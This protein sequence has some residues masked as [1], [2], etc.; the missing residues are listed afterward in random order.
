[1]WISAV[2]LKIL[3]QPKHPDEGGSIVDARLW[4]LQREWS[5]QER[6]LRERR[7]QALRDGVIIKAITRET[8]DAF[9]DH[10]I[11][12]Q[13]RNMVL[14]RSVHSTIRHQLQWPDTHNT[15]AQLS[16]IGFSNRTLTEHLV[17]GAEREPKFKIMQEYLEKK[18]AIWE[19][20]IS[21]RI[22]EGTLKMVVPNN[23]VPR[24]W[25]ID[26]HDYGLL[27]HTFDGF[28]LYYI[29]YLPQQTIAFIEDAQLLDYAI[30]KLL[31]NHAPIYTEFPWRIPEKETP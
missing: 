14:L 31:H 17:V 2:L 21:D 1:M 12:N 8:L 20:K 13:I 18:A 5:E 25:T 26:Q 11:L 27:Y 23:D 9:F 22:A 16:I 10:E 7:E 15:G 24:L 30:L 4:K 3:M 19:A 29:L 28:S 6:L